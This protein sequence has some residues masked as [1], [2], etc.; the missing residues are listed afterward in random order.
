MFSLLWLAV[1]AVPTAVLAM[2]WRGAPPPTVAEI[3]HTA[4]RRD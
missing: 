3:L 2:V 4:E 1:V